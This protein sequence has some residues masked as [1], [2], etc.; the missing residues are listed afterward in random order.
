MANEE[1][2][3]RLLNDVVGWNK[4]R[5]ENR[6]V[7]IDL[8]EADLRE[9]NLSGAN[10]FNVNLN[11]AII[12]RAD[13][14]K[15]N[16]N[17]ANLYRANL[18]SANLMGTEFKYAELTYAKL[19]SAELQGSDLMGADLRGG[20]LIGAYLMGANLQ[21]T[22]LLGVDL[23]RSNL[24]GT[25]LS[26]A[27]LGGTILREIDLS[28]TKGLEEIHHEIPSTVGIDTLKL[29]KG[30]IPEK[31]LRG[32]GL[33]DWEIESA[34]LY[35]PGL[36][37]DQVTDIGYKVIQLRAGS[38]IQYHSVFISYCSKDDAFAS[39]LYDDLQNSG[40]RCWFAP[41]DIQGGKKLHE[42]IDVAIQRNDRTLLILSENSMNSEWVKTE[43]A[44]TRKKEAK[45]K[46]Q[47]LFPIRLIN[48]SKI[49]AWECF[50]ADMGKDSAREI[51][52]YFIP[53][54]SNWKDEKSYKSVFE[55]LLKDLRATEEGLDGK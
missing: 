28:E 11:G 33:S 13:L 17:K 24:Q 20:N 32:C 41:E 10:L 31:F 47:I 2:L 42:Q 40:V 21:Y 35:R 26:G 30:N 27:F 16:L 39:R 3:K 5:S 25:Q 51:R 15:A 55:R 7:K 23:G 48:F 45:E 22:D 43:I 49:Q 36:S 6:D 44:N 1:Q 18:S 54:F 50:D 19:E 14:K 29:S 34:K 46:R 4:W 52:E 9:S 53:D 8:M 37:A 12:T 38:P